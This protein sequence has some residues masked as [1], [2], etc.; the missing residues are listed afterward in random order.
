M[1]VLFCYVIA[2]LGQQEDEKDRG[3]PVTNKHKFKGERN[4]EN[5]I[6]R[7]FRKGIRKCKIYL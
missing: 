2:A 7:R 5:H 6:E 1:G 4:Y 3:I